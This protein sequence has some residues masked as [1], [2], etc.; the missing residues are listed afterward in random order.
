MLG[1]LVIREMK[2]KIIVRYHFL[3]TKMARIKRTTIAYVGK[4]VEKL[5]PSLLARM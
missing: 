1:S 2:I 4:H 3:S 5:E